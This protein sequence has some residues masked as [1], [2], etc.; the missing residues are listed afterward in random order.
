MV[1]FFCSVVGLIVDSSG[2]PHPANWIRARPA[3][4]L[5]SRRGGGP[6]SPLLGAGRLLEPARW[7]L[8]RHTGP[9]VAGAGAVRTCKC[10]KVSLDTFTHRAGGFKISCM[11]SVCVRNGW[12]RGT[13]LL[14]VFLEA[15][16]DPNSNSLEQ[17]SVMRGKGCSLAC[18][19][20]F[21][22]LRRFIPGSP[23]QIAGGLMCW[24]FFPG[25][26]LFLFAWLLSSL[27]MQRSL[28]C[29]EYAHRESCAGHAMHQRGGQRSCWPPQPHTPARGCVGLLGGTYTWAASGLQR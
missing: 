9:C 29:G 19:R 2:S 12:E 20:V 7:P 25:N 4:Q 15:S 22:P 13:R 3:R 23:N 6:A 5:R 27:Q 17:K 8:R 18:S 21:F 14:Q 26:E 28:A 11:S 16:R 1:F 24:C 10:W